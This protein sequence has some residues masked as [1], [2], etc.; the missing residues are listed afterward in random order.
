[1]YMVHTRSPEAECLPLLRNSLKLVVWYIHVHALIALYVQGTYTFI[2]ANVC[3]YMVQTRLYSI[4]TTLHFPSGPISLA[5]PASLSSVQAQLLQR[6]L[7]LACQTHHV[8]W[9]Y[10]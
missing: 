9:I 8:R 2:N 7:E 1:M 3:M 5:T 4:T 6:S 10:I